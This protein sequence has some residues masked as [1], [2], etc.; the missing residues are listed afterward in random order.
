MLF[1]WLL[2]GELQKKKI[3]FWNA[4]TG[5]DY[6]EGHIFSACKTGSAF[7]K[8]KLKPQHYDSK[9]CVKIYSKL[10]NYK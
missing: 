4:K 8:L 10:L 9:R 2:F 6:S 3:N 5:S 7:K 1:L